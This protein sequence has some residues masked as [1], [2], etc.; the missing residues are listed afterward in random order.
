M[1]NIS[2]C[3]YEALSSKPS[4]A[5]AAIS[6]P[7]GLSARGFTSTMVQSDFT[8]R[9]YNPLICWAAS[10]LLPV[11]L[12]PS[13]ICMACESVMPWRMS[14]GILMIL[15]GNFSARS[16]MLVPPSEQPIMIGP[17]VLRSSRMAKYI[18]RASFIFFA[19]YSVFTGFPAGPVCLVTKVPPN[20]CFASSNALSTFAMCTPP[21][22]PLVNLPRP[23]PPARIWLLITT[24]PFS[25][26]IAFRADSTSL[27]LCAGRPSGT[28]IPNLAISWAPWYS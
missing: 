23:R 2:F 12:R 10:A 27:I 8:N 4:F 7:S 26:A 1:A 17:A 9:L 15:S 22:S 5:S 20:I 14:M 18:S 25:S 13:T 3:R 19:M 24:S 16:S 21:C 11:T 28:L 6:L